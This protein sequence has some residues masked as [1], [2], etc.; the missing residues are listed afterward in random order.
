MHLEWGGEDEFGLEVVLGVFEPFELVHVSGGV[1]GTHLG[2]KHLVDVCEVGRH[3]P[4]KEEVLLPGALVQLAHSLHYVHLQSLHLVAPICV[5]VLQ[6]RPG[7]L[8]MPHLLSPLLLQTLNQ[9]PV[10][11]VYCLHYLRKLFLGT[12]EVVDAI[13][14]DGVGLVDC[15]FNGPQGRVEF[16]LEFFAAAV[17][18]DN[19]MSFVSAV[20]VHTGHAKSLAVV[21]A[22]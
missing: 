7:V 21:E 12:F 15:V 8:H 6:P 10:E 9:P 14:F 16:C 5:L 18:R 3:I 22:V 17:E 13:G 11:I 1:I 4:V 19:L 20:L 2:F